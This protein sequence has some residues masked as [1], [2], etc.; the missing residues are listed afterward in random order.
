MGGDGVAS[1]NLLC[2][3]RT[4]LACTVSYRGT[5]PNCRTCGKVLG[6]HANVCL[7]AGRLL[8]AG[9]ETLDDVAVKA[10]RVVSVLG[11]L[12]ERRRFAFSRHAC[13]Q[14]TRLAWTSPQALCR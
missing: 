3:V 12:E 13:I 1:P 4:I 11:F 6:F 2:Y 8:Q 9:L 10:W 5:L 14:C 7:S